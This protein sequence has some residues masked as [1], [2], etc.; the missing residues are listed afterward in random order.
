MALE[1]TWFGLVVLL[2]AIYAILDGFDLGVGFW[3]LFGRDEEEK[4]INFKAIGPVWD[5]NE[6]WLLTGGGA[7]FAAFPPVY[8]TIFSGFYLALIL[9]LF[10]LIF[11]AIALEFR[12]QSESPVWRRNWDLA[13]GLGSSLVA[14]L[15]GTAL[16]NVLAGLPLDANGDYY[17]GLLGLLRPWPV[18]C[19]LGGLALL[20]VQGAAWMVLKTDGTLRDTYKKRLHQ[21]W[22]GFTSLYVL[23][24]ILAFFLAP[25]LVARAMSRGAFV[26]PLEALAL[27]LLVAIP[28]L[29]GAGKDLFA[30]LASSGFILLLFALAAATL[31]PILVPS[32]PEAARSLTA[33]NSAAGQKSLGTMLVVALLGV[34]I[35]LAY[36]VYI[37]KT[38]LGRITKA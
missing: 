20:A 27:A 14:I 37:Y 3:H 8:A 10:G 29:T 21:A 30:F 35:V 26:W 1:I 18:L 13:F 36:T 22:I 2:L 32:V 15:L 5:G 28:L 4:R 33:H 17:G 23:A 12:G 7:M 9:L 19:G 24:I 11:R 16:G 25:E 38:F 34:P 6:V 31:F